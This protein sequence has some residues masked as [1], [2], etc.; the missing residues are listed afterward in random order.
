MAARVAFGILALGSL[1]SPLQNGK[2]RQPPPARRPF[3]YMRLS[4]IINRLMTRWIRR[5]GSGNLPRL[6]LAATKCSLHLASLL[7]HESPRLSSAPARQI[8]KRGRRN[9]KSMGG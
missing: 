5:G 8:R 9:F 4:K 2:G 3:L 1:F 7:G 6:L